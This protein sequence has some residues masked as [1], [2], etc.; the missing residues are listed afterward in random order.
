[1]QYY[2]AAKR[3]ETIESTGKWM[4]IERIILSELSQSQKD[5]YYIFSFIIA[6]N[7]N[8]HI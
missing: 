3:N 6:L 4:E 1:M 2:A 5:K 7:S 8:L